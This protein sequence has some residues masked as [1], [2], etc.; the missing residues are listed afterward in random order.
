MENLKKPVQFNRYKSVESFN[1]ATDI[2]SSTLSIVKLDDNI[3]EIYLGRTKISDSNLLKENIELRNLID[4]LSISIKEIY[5]DVDSIRDIKTKQ[6]YQSQSIF[7]IKNDIK[8][9]KSEDLHIFEILGEINKKISNLDNDIIPSISDITTL[10]QNIDAVLK[11]LLNK[12]KNNQSEINKLKSK[13]ISVTEDISI[14]EKN[15]KGL[16]EE[17]IHIFEIINGLQS[18]SKTIMSDIKFIKNDNENINDEILKLKEKIKFIS[19]VNVDNYATLEEADRRLD[20]L[21]KSDGLF[22]TKIDNINVDIESIKKDVENLQS[23]ERTTNENIKTLEDNIKKNKDDISLLEYIIQENNDKIES[24]ENNIQDSN[25]KINLLIERIE[26]LSGYESDYLDGFND[27]EQKIKDLVSKDESIQKTINDLE[28]SKESINKDILLL[29]EQIEYL[30]GDN[31]D[32]CEELEYIIQKLT[33]LEISNKTIQ[34]TTNELK[35]NDVNLNNNIISLKE[36]IDYL[37]N[38]DSEKSDELI[39][40]NES[41]SKLE[42]KYNTHNQLI[43]NT[44]VGLNEVNTKI[45]EIN[46]ELVSLINIVEKLSGTDSDIESINK[47]LVDLKYINEE[48]QK[49]IENIKSNKQNKLEWLIL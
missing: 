12:I 14:I 19:G 32:N 6:N 18:I 44:T 41:L 26:Y 36:K 29:K 45:V 20:N 27:I 40:I 39:G 15:I 34:Q 5:S 10:K 16:Q 28:E 25:D 8:S 13:D 31:S 3:M 1:S 23:F 7:D 17:D 9:L 24:L 38:A 30:S 42:D 21:E 43:Q 37:F 49:E 47:E 48:L 46:D 11:E 22:K 33:D 35:E 4:S 2:T